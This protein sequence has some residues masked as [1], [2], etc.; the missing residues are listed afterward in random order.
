MD[1]IPR[2]GVRQLPRHITRELSGFEVEAV[3]PKILTLELYRCARSG[4]TLKR[5]FFP[6]FAALILG[7]G[8]SLA[9][10]NG[11]FLPSQPSAPGG[12]DQI[13]STTGARCSQSIN[14]SGSYLDI[15]VTATADSGDSGFF[16]DGRQ[17]N[18]SFS[19]G[20]VTGYVRIIIP[21]GERPA[22]LD[23]IR[24]YELE[25]RKLEQ[26]VLLLRMGAE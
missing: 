8:L 6:A 11:L 20:G 19:D 2:Q 1:E 15:G 16:S 25:L 10:T 5:L 22:R 17:K 12:Q 13:Q 18:R 21:L 3:Y 14:S 4:L 24:L 9:D 26:E 7:S 23:C